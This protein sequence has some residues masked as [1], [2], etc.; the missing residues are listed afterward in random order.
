MSLRGAPS[1]PLPLRQDR[2][3]EGLAMAGCLTPSGSYLSVPFPQR[4]DGR[5]DQQFQYK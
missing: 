3:V 1:T 4:K 2:L 5:I